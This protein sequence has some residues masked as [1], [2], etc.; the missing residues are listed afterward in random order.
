MWSEF[1]RMEAEKER[2]MSF[3]GMHGVALAT[4]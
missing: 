2:L 3:C 1:D 4:T